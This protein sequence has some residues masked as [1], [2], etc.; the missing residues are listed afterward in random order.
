MSFI[1]GN[2]K[3]SQSRIQIQIKFDMFLK[4]FSGFEIL[5]KGAPLAWQRL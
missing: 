2:I 3:L 1:V 4:K 5:Y